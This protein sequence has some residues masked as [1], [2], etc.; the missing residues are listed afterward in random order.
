M[1]YACSGASYNSY[2]RSLPKLTSAGFPMG[3]KKG[4]W[5]VH[6]PTDR[7][8][9]GF[10]PGDELRSQVLKL[11][12]LYMKGIRG[13][14]FYKV[15]LKDEPRSRG[16]VAIGKIR[17]FAAA[18]I[19]QCVLLKMYFGHFCGIFMDN[20]LETETLAGVNPFSDTW[21]DIMNKLSKFPHISDGDVKNYDKVLALV[22]I[23]SFSIMYRIMDSMIGISHLRPMFSAMM[24]DC[25]QPV[26]IILKSLVMSNGGLPS[27]IF[28]TLLSN[29]IS[30]SILIRLAWLNSP[31]S[32]Y[33]E[34]KKN[35]DRFE[36]MVVFFAMGDDN[37]YSLAKE[38]S[39][40]FNFE[41]ILEYFGSVGITYT[42]PQKTDEV[43]KYVD[44]SKASIIKRSWV[45][46]DE[47]NRYMA[48][49]EKASIGKMLTMTLNTGPMTVSQRLYSAYIS[50][51][52]EMVQYGR[53]EYERIVPIIQ[54][55][56]NSAGINYPHNYTYD[57]VMD[58][59]LNGNVPWVSQ[60]YDIDY[61]IELDHTSANS[62]SEPITWR[63]TLPEHNA[64]H[65]VGSEICLRAFH[66]KLM[67][68]C[69][70]SV[71]P[72]SLDRMINTMDSRFSNNER[73]T[74]VR[75]QLIFS[76]KERI[77]EAI[78]HSSFRSRSEQRRYNYF[79]LFDIFVYQI[80][81]LVAYFIKYLTDKFPSLPGRRVFII[82]TDCLLLFRNA[83]RVIAV[84]L[85]VCILFNTIQIYGT[86]FGEYIEVLNALATVIYCFYNFPHEEIDQRIAVINIVAFLIYWVNIY[87]AYFGKCI[88]FFNIM[89]LFI[90]WAYVD[91]FNYSI[92]RFILLLFLSSIISIFQ[93]NDL[94]YAAS[95]VNLLSMCWVVSME[96][97]RY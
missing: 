33:K 46:S 87:T 15:A 88:A 44:I 30:N 60:L 54:D 11:R 62:P 51:Q 22:H 55:L 70:Q 32:I 67:E 28:I 71:S 90:H 84:Y 64:M 29:N 3:K 6:C 26:Y 80:Q 10:V 2:C 42:N 18:P 72:H 37:L 38:I 31:A 45:W 76:Y 77:H 19:E 16:K 92:L 34:P 75:D 40:V 24:T 20:C 35:L 14:V 93:K 95:L 97:G 43:Y 61:E 82:F 50:M 17:C 69:M 73:Y 58:R 57:T 27:G 78:L 53:D 52:F 41:T 48:P 47:Y 1:N 13:P 94:H 25:V 56:Y 5:L 21:T 83:M 96:S 86:I 9:D 23:W 79:Q 49:V 63:S 66:I 74:M 4:D 68:S 36:L 39:E 8:P 12:D 81:L 65:F 89:G 91:P 85:V 7:A 59:I